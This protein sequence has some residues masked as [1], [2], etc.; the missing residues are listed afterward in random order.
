[1]KKLLFTMLALLPLSMW[2]QDN[3]WELNQEEEIKQEEKA[4]PKVDVKYLKG[5]VPE[6]DG[7][8]VFSKHIEAPGKSADQIFDILKQY[9]ER[10]T[11]TTNQ[12]QSQILTADAQ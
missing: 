9:M 11:K 3:T 1:M 7:M 10:L 6:V 2:A 4:K 8:V 12:I 5:A